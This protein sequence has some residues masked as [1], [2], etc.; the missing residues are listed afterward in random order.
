MDELVPLL[1]E[2]YHRYWDNGIPDARGE[3]A[4]RRGDVGKTKEAPK[5]DSTSTQIVYFGRCIPW[6]IIDQMP[7]MNKYKLQPVSTESESEK[8]RHGR[9]ESADVDSIVAFVDVEA[10]FC[11][12]VRVS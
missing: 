7:S 8:S 4:I 5:A 1:G 2:P 11:V 10:D 9:T 12:G 3:S 6:M